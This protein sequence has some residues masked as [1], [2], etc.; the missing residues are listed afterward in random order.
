V[1]YHVRSSSLVCWGVWLCVSMSLSICLVSLM[2]TFAYI[3]E[4][5]KDA[6]LECGVM[7]VCFSW[8]MSSVVLLILN[9][10]GRGESSCIF[11]DRS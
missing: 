11:C 7:G 1:L 2:G 10:Y 5:S 4:M 3:F 6:N 8:S 9:V